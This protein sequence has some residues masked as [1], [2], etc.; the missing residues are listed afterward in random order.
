[1]PS[2]KSLYSSEAQ[3]RASDFSIQLKA[4]PPSGIKLDKVC[5]EGGFQKE[6][7]WE[8]Q[9]RKLR[10]H[11]PPRCMYPGEFLS[12][13]RAFKHPR[14]PTIGVT[15]TRFGNSPREDA[16]I[17][18]HGTIYVADA[19]ERRSIMAIPCD[20]IPFGTIRT[21]VFIEERQVWE[22]GEMKR[23]WRSILETL[24]EQSYLLPDD[25]LSFLIGKDTYHVFPTKYRR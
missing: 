6:G 22:G 17:D 2:A 14:W 19:S 1:M 23:G 15:A 25:E 3:T 4:P 18:R 5:S 16:G 13:L 21:A 24:V 20:C 7:Q 10:P 11:A 9:A 12:I 8:S